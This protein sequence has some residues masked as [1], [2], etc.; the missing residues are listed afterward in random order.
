M[1][2]PSL[3][4]LVLALAAGSMPVALCQ[5][6]TGLDGALSSQAADVEIV[7]TLSPGVSE[8]VPL[9]AVAKRQLAREVIAGQRPLGEAAALF[10]ELNGL[11]P[12]LRLAP[13]VDTSLN[14]PA[15]T[16]E[17]WLC[18]QVTEYV[19]VELAA[20]P[21]VAQATLA[22]LEGE[23]FAEL[24]QRGAIQLPDTSALPSGRELLERVRPK[25]TP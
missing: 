23:F 22:R 7:S 16:A 17:G 6:P 4:L 10:R 24:R 18:R 2:V 13:Q 9:R 14:I 1:K 11:T 21:E 3:K 25:A 12:E 15:D 19:R 5:P 8:V 20:E